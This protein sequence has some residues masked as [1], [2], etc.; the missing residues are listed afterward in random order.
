M[1]IRRH[2]R[3][4]LQLGLLL[5]LGLRLIGLVLIIGD[6][7]EGLEDRLLILVARVLLVQEIVQVP[8]MARRP[9]GIP[10]NRLAIR[11]QDLILKVLRVPQLLLRSSVQATETGVAAANI[12]H[13]NN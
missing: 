7:A 12:A 3:L 10:S 4:L 5:F 2:P 11:F 9:H 6:V 13:Y 8:I 1:L